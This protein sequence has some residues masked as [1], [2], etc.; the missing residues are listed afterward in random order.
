MKIDKSVMITAI[1]ALSVIQIA[2]MFFEIN[3]TFRTYIVGAILL[4]LG[5]SIPKEVI[6]KFLKG[7]GK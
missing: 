2:A 6:I 1:I 4:I 3:G 5:V 7:G